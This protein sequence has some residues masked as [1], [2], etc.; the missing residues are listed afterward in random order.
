MY[1]TTVQF[2]NLLTRIYVCMYISLCWNINKKIDR[3]V[4]ALYE[5]Q[6]DFD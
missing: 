1:V 2:N 5:Q 3:F 6:I 4:E